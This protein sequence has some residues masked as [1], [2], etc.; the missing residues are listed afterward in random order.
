MIKYSSLMPCTGIQDLSRVEVGD[1]VYL[2]SME[3]NHD[4]G[5]FGRTVKNIEVATAGEHKGNILLT[6]S[7]GTVVPP[8]LVWPDFK[9]LEKMFD[10]L[11]KL[12]GK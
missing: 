6:L 12:E 8:L 2:F 9:E 4:W 5:V 7:D 11:I 10:S 3:K 1:K